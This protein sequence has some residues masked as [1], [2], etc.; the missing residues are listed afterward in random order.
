MVWFLL[1]LQSSFSYIILSSNKDYV[2]YL[3]P[4]PCI[5]HSS[6][7]RGCIM[8]C[9]WYFQFTPIFFWC[10]MCKWLVSPYDPQME[11]FSMRDWI[12]FQWLRKCT[13]KMTLVFSSEIYLQYTPVFSVWVISLPH[14]YWISERQSWV[15]VFIYS[16]ISNI[17]EALLSVTLCFH[18]LF[19]LPSGLLG[20]KNNNTQN[21]KVVAKVRTDT[22]N[23]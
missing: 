23:A 9:Q 21:S 1:S 8:C 20:N 12:L 7:L 6:S 15:P 16:F 14:I 5:C 17:W 4:N 22:N 18:D 13:T 19:Y 10:V 11:I 3:P 2:V